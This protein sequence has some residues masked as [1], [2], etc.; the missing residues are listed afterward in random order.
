MTIVYSKINAKTKC[1]VYF[2]GS[3]YINNWAPYFYLLSIYA[4]L[5]VL[6]SHLGT[7]I[8]TEIPEEMT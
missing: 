1:I 2:L 4:Y 8:V 6:F 3:I 7:Y 5:L